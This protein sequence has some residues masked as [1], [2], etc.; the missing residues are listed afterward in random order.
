MLSGYDHK[1]NIK[2]RWNHP[3]ETE[4]G[5]YRITSTLQNRWRLT[6]CM[7]LTNSE[8]VFILDNNIRAFKY[9]HATKLTIEEEVGNLSKKTLSVTHLIT[10]KKLAVEFYMRFGGND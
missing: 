8:R 4:D 3:V 9:Y 6:G 5:Q 1:R 7:L 2:L 10:T